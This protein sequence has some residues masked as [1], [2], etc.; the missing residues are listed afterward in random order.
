M[1]MYLRD[2]LLKMRV[3]HANFF[4]FPASRSFH[5]D[6]V[7]AADACTLVKLCNNA[8]RDMVPNFDNTT[9]QAFEGFPLAQ[10]LL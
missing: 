5:D 4:L 3:A 10:L 6:A 8:S 1:S 9:Y 2:G 7:A